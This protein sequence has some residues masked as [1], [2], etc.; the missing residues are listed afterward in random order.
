MYAT[1]D[2]YTNTFGGVIIPAERFNYMMREASAFIDCITFNRTKQMNPADITDEIR[3]AT[4][5][6]A[7]SMYTL[8]DGSG[9]ETGESKSSE[10]VGD[11][12]VSFANPTTKSTKV[13]RN[14]E[15]YYNL[16]KRYL[17]HTGLLYRGLD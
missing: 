4:C 5:S 13:I 6:V 12:Q 11:Y 1:Y 14:E 16:A 15:I 2:Y 8:T 3:N 17:L 10:K 7:E 9:I